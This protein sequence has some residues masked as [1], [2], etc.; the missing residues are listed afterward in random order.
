MFLKSF[1]NNRSL[2]FFYKNEQIPTD[3]KISIEFKNEKIE[4]ILDEIL[5]GTGLTYHVLDK[6]IVITSNQTVKGELSSQQQKSVSGKVT[7][8][9]GSPLPGVTI[10]VKGTTIGI[11]TD[12][13]GN[14]SITKV[15]EN[16]T[17]QFS[18]V[19]MKTQEI[20][21]GNK[22]I[23]NVTLTEDN[24]GIEEVVAIGYGTARKAD[25]TGSVVSVNAEKL[26]ATI[27]TNL[28]LTLQ[29]V[30]P[31]LEVT[32]SSY[33]AGANQ[34]LTIRGENSMSA[35]NAPLII[36]DG[37]PYDGNL[38]DINPE[39]I[40][41]INVLKDASASAI[42]G[43]RSSN[44][45]I[46]ITTKEGSSGK[47][48]VS[49][50]HTSGIASIAHKVDMQNGEQYIKGLQE[51]WR[52]NG[53]IYNDP[54]QVLQSNEH[55]NYQA[56]IEIDWIDHAY[57]KA[58]TQD[59]QISIS[60]GT[61]KTSYYNSIGYHY[62]EGL[63]MND[64]Y[65]RFTI[66]SNVSHNPTDWLEVG[67]KLQFTRSD[68]GGTSPALSNILAM[69]PYGNVYE[70]DGSYD[71][72]P[73]DP[74]T[75]FISPFANIDATNDDIRTG[76]IINGYALFKPLKG[77]S[78]RLNLG[79][80]INGMDMGSYYPKTTQSGKSVGSYGTIT[81]DNNFRSTFENILNYKH[82][83][84]AHSLDLTGLYSREKT[85]A[86]QSYSYGRGFVSDAPL[87]HF[88]ESASTKDISSGFRETS[89]ES[90]MG[91]LTYDFNKLYYLTL[92]VRR[93]GY[94]GFGAN[95]KYGT[96]PS[97]SVGWNI[98]DQEFFK[99]SSALEFIS[100]L[101]LRF[102][103]GLNGNMAIPPYRTLDSFSSM[104]YV[105]G[106]NSNTQ[107][108][109]RNSV[110][111]NPGLKWENTESANIGLDF[112]I[113]KNRISGTIE[114]W[115]SN[116]NNLLMQQSVP[117]MNGYLSVWNNVGELGNKGIE[118]SLNTVN[119][120][121]GN[122]SWNSYFNFSSSKDEILTLASGATKDLANLW[123]VGERLNINYNY[124]RDGVWQ[125]GQEDEI[126]NSPQKGEKPGSARI[127]DINN[128]GKL[129][130][131]DRVVQGSPT[132]KW[133]AG[134]TNEFKYK[135]WTL[136][137]LF[138]AVWGNR[139]ENSFLD[140]ITWTPANN[141]NFPDVDYWSPE[142]PANYTPS[143]GYQNP[144]RLFFY[145]DASYVRIKDVKLSYNFSPKG[146]LETWGM[147]NLQ[148]SLSCWN[149]YTFTNWIGWDPEQPIG[150]FNTYSN[151]THP[152]P[153]TLNFSVKIDL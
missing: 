129:N 138:N 6:D 105:Y 38:N 20:A 46:L 68:Y 152:V 149:L 144:Y 145:E 74:K 118:L 101:K 78:Y 94:S 41:S 18:F 60:G 35:S 96:F 124:L 136:S 58:Y 21:I 64:Q 51:Y 77:L 19:G 8:T 76:G 65:K 49:F 2:T 71:F 133:R 119:M 32:S 111:G 3:A 39:D 98:S 91:R 116:S 47:P 109:F 128:D 107:T 24:I 63:A 134:L 117:V 110:I 100:F 53:T 5:A 97:G 139:M 73:V 70:A 45:V 66:L 121:K 25:L 11:V 112:G 95:N 40:G 37:I 61:D 75:Y 23:I 31:G 52:F 146:I 90:L 86:S 9:T 130:D 72:Y 87:Y 48:R 12:I 57:R 84:G 125:L 29:G 85:Q 44:G 15:P 115:K 33:S 92:T 140:P 151:S 150:E 54:L 36:L 89:I 16:A 153:R 28:A 67:T 7:D 50:T 4:V 59:D 22:T 142:N 102:S 103:Y 13:D 1:R 106:D 120:I 137:M 99:S 34:I 108:G 132:P 114:L 143:A 82:T 43:A 10:V 141:G 131:A 17:L 42:Y 56:G 83:A 80:N 14:Y 81:N 126:A 88:M 27:N 69:S 148:F 127:K 26:K 79:F 123:I 113:L 62:Q 135:G 93:D 122:F 104:P 147:D 30:V 55:P